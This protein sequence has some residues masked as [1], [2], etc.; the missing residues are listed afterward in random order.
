LGCES[1]NNAVLSLPVWETINNPESLALAKKFRG[2][3]QTPLDMN[4]CVTAKPSTGLLPS[5][6]H[7]SAG[8]GANDPWR[9][10]AS[11]QNFPVCM[12]LSILRVCDEIPAAAPFAPGHSDGSVSWLSE[13]QITLLH[14]SW[15]S[16]SVLTQIPPPLLF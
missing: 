4:F 15:F 13:I 9:L 1:G 7:C 10:T 2:T 16:V 6:P 5:F 12:A 8:G 14:G 11:R 3:L